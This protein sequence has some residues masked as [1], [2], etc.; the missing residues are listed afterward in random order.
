M[1]KDNTSVK[2]VV[3]SSK[4]TPCFFLLAAA[5]FPFHSKSKVLSSC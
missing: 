4:E 3:A 1:V 5:F 2:T